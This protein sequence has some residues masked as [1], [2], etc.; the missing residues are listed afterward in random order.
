MIC[1]LHWNGCVDA[2]PRH[3]LKLKNR[4]QR[5]VFSHEVLPGGRVRLKS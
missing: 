2:S 5:Y 3:H 4:T 1:S